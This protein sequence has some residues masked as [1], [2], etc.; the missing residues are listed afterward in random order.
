MAKDIEIKVD[1][2]QIRQV[3]KLL[4]AVP[5]GWP[6]VASRAINR[7]ATRART[8][9]VR[10]I[11][12]EVKIR[13][14]D[15]RKQIRVRRASYSR[16]EA[17]LVIWG[18]RIPLIRFG[19]RQTRRGVTYQIGKAG[20]RKLIEHAFI[21]TMPSGHHGVFIRGR[22]QGPGGM[23]RRLPIFE[24]LGPS[25]P[26]IYDGA[27]NLARRMMGETQTDLHDELNT[28]V[29]VILEKAGRS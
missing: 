10:A 20:G 17:H 1:R 11:S 4:A 21:T 28:Q 24:R 23:V 8:R 13:Q 29:K 3:Q 14:A 18:R 27:A 19:A 15:V 26:G 7:T 16:L 22:G 2:R 5:R 6:K 25:V 12:S 9:V